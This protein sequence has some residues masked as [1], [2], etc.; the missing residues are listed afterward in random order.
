[1]EGVMY[2]MY[3]IIK[4]LTETKEVTELHASGGFA[5]S[6]LWL[7]MLADVSNIKVL[8]SGAVESSALGAVMLGAEAMKTDAKFEH[9]VLA[10]YTPNEKNNMVYKKCFDTF[11]RLYQLLKGEMV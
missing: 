5:R 9:K 3:S 8:V 11:E 6:G 10:S 2:S 4:I 1:M 7:Q